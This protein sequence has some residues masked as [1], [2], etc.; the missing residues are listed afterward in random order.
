[1][2]RKFLTPV[3]LPHGSTLP[4]AGSTGD[5]FFKTTDKKVYTYD[6]TNWVATSSG[7]GASSLATLS[8]VTQTSPADGDVLTYDEITSSWINLNVVSLL[9]SWG[10]APGTIDGGTPTTTYN[11]IYDGGDESSF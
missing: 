1:L 10:F 9:A 3:N 4:A 11:A 6:G 8:D 7:A 5:L 2:S